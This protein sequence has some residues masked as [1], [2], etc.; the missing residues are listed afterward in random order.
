MYK[1]IVIEDSKLFRNIIVSELENLDNVQLLVAE[2]F[3]EADKITEE[4]E[5][6]L[7][8]AVTDLNLPDSPR[9]EVIDM[10]SQKQIPSI[11]LSGT[12]S[13]DLRERLFSLNVID[14]IIKNN[15]SS[16]KYTARLIKT[17]I[18]NTKRK[19][20]IAEDSKVASSV[21][22]ALLKQYKFKEVIQAYDGQEALDKINADPLISLAVIDA[23]MPVMD[24]FELIRN[25]RQKLSPDEMRIIGISGYDKKDLSAKFLKF[26]AN[27]FLK[28]PF[29]VEEFLCRVVQNIQEAE[30]IKNL[31][32]L[33]ST[34][35]LTGLYN[36]RGFFKQSKQLLLNAKRE[37]LN[38]IVAM[39]DID[40]FKL[41]NDT[42]GHAAGDKV[43]KGIADK[44]NSYKRG[45]DIVARIGG[46]EFCF[47]FPNFK[48]EN[49]ES[50][51]NRLIKEIAENS[52]E[53]E[54]K[55]IDVTV[56][57][58][59]CSAAEFDLDKM[60]AIADKKLYLAKENGR[61][62]LEF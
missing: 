1:I 61:N 41:I 54:G 28:K 60:M 10:L 32:L 20:I 50:Y 17:L 27:D 62:K 53:I 9:G 5:G 15:P 43:I 38:P 11:V 40:S 8:L 22:S 12:Y 19:A 44:L 13:S 48:S 30:S 51:F 47:L 23:H 34:D 29:I 49:I 46:E 24:G 21:I 37:G 42:H 3:E 31:K 59:I 33:N 18:D 35:Y 55:N 36:R 6:D 16:V 45:S 56:S 26:G 25:I 52:I 58:G 4:H 14:Y 57:I 39:I 7:F 2:S